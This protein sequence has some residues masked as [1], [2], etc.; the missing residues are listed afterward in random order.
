[1]EAIAHTCGV[2]RQTLWLARKHDPDFNCDLLRAL[3]LY[4]TELVD[5]MMACLSDPKTAGN[6][7]VAK[8]ILAQRFP[9]RY[10]S[11][12]RLRMSAQQAQEGYED[13]M[14]DPKLNP[15]QDTTAA[16]I[17]RLVDRMLTED[18]A[19]NG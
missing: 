6:A 2:S 9:Q 8:A 13:D 14:N 4:E 15:A 12:P 7:S 3:A 1:M 18:E 10:G 11:D 5:T 16:V 17:G 19:S